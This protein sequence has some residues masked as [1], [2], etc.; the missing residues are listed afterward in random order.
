MLG[1][2]GEVLIDTSGRQQKRHGAVQQHI[3]YSAPSPHTPAA[4]SCSHYPPPYK[5]EAKIFKRWFSVLN[6]S[7][8][9]LQTFTKAV[10]AK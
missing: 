5:F 4:E 9:N 3:D 6:T 7:P 2:S 10:T 1:A 8:K